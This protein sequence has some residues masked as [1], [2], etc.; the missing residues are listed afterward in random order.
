M[1]RQ[2]GHLEVV[3]VLIAYEADTSLKDVDGDDAASFAAQAGHSRVVEYLKEK[4][5]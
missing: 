4:N 3:K 2:K 1:L 5:N